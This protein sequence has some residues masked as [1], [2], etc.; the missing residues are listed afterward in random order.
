VNSSLPR[1]YTGRTICEVDRPTFED[2]IER[3]ER[4]WRAPGTEQLAELFAADASYRT[5][6]FEEPYRGLE[7]IAR[8]WE[9]EREGPDEDFEMNSEVVAVEGDTGVA[10]L[11]VRY[12]KPGGKTYRDVWIVTLDGRGRCSA[13]EEWPFWPRE[14]GGSYHSPGGDC[15]ERGPR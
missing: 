3:Y 4:A 11:E 14:S 9:A 15:S 8:M 13:F 5:A 10:R 7:A 12:L 1:W 6:P 2:W